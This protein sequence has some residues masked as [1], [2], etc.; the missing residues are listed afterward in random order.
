MTHTCKLC[1]QAFTGPQASHALR[2]HTTHC[3][4]RIREMEHV[5]LEDV[6]EMA[7]VVVGERYCEGEAIEV[8]ALRVELDKLARWRK[9]VGM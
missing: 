7:R 4:R 5:L 6:A 3:K 2:G 1:G 8:V 9:A